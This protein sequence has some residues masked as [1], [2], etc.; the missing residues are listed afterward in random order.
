MDTRDEVMKALLSLIIEVNEKTNYTVNYIYG[1][2][3]LVKKEE[4]RWNKIKRIFKN[5]MSRM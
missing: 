4:T 2:P 1:W 5:D 3:Y